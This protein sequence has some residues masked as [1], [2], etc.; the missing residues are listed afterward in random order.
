MNSE[1]KRPVY[2]V[3]LAPRLVEVVKELAVTHHC[4]VSREIEL[5]I[6]DRVYGRSQQPEKDKGMTA[7]DL[8]VQAYNKLQEA[9]VPLQQIDFVAEF[10]EDIAAALERLNGV[11]RAEVMVVVPVLKIAGRQYEDA[12]RI[13]TSDEALPSRPTPEILRGVTN[14]QEPKAF[15]LLGKSNK[16]P[17]PTGLHRLECPSIARQR[18]LEPDRLAVI[19]SDE[20]LNTFFRAGFSRCRTCEPDLA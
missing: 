13:V 18:L 7:I 16:F 4:S 3:T 6:E 1:R 9:T 2:S 17:P 19:Q 20:E 10:G 8:I 5:A 12:Q 11:E 15:Y 14:P